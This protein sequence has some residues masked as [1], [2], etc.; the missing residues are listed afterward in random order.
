MLPGPASQV[1]E[2]V[3]EVLDVIPAI[4]RV[5]RTVRP[6]Y[7]CRSCTDGVVQAKMLPRLI[8]A[9]AAWSVQCA[10]A[11]GRHNSLFSGSEGGAKSWVILASIS[12]TLQNS[13]ISIRRPTWPTCWSA[14]FPRR[15]KSHQLHELLAWN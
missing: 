14:S 2:D 6:K 1:G 9:T 11:L 7:A 13:M 15:T 10:I 8:C 3:S 4:L 12:S 5:L